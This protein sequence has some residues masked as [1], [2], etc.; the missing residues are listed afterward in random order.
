MLI[1]VGNEVCGK[2][3]S[4]VGRGYA[5]K[6]CAHPE[7]F[8]ALSARGPPVGVAMLISTYCFGRWK[9]SSFGVGLCKIGVPAT[10]FLE[11]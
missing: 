11:D 5:N 4:N 3:N 2:G 9:G 1:R 7:R 10:E 6:T 8:H